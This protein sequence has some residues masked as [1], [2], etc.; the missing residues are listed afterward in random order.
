MR[1]LCWISFTLAGMIPDSLLL[2][3]LVVQI[4]LL[5]SYCPQRLVLNGKST[6]NTIT[7]TCQVIYWTWQRIPK[8]EDTDWSIF[9]CHSVEAQNL[10]LMCASLYSSFFILK[11]F[12]F[13]LIMK[14][15]LIVVSSQI[16]QGF[17]EG[18]LYVSILCLFFFRKRDAYYNI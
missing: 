5:I 13:S 16:Y 11:A 10:C 7:L 14:K 2:T 9:V 1:K 12:R 15:E 6:L 17:H 8:S 3:R 4:G 18:I